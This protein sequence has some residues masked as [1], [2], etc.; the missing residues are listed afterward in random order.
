MLYSE[1]GSQ[2]LTETATSYRTFLPFWVEVALVEK[3]VNKNT[4]Y[5]ATSSF[6][7]QVLIILFHNRAT[8]QFG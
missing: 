8:P 1:T 5:N 3:S 2:C 6:Q 7:R 4:R